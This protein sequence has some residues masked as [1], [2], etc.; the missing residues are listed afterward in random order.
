[1]DSSQAPKDAGGSGAQEFSFLTIV[2]SAVRDRRRIMTA[3]LGITGV[4][5]LSAL[6]YYVFVQPTRHV[7]STAFR[8]TFDRA[9]EDLYPNGLPFG[10]SDVI[11]PSV[12]QQVFDA[13][14][15]GDY[16]PFG[17]FK[18]GLVVERGATERRLVDAQYNG[19][20]SNARLTPV[21]RQ[22]LEEE[23]RARLDALP[24]E[25]RL[26]FVRPADC[27][28][29]GEI[30]SAALAGILETWAREAEQKRG[31]LH[32]DVSVAGPTMFDQTAPVPYLVARVDFT[33]NAITRA[34]DAVDRIAKLPGALALRSGGRNGMTLM[35]VRGR[36]NDLRERV[37]EPLLVQAA[38][39][40]GGDAIAWLDS[41]RAS[42]RIE[43]ESSQ[44]RAE[45]FRT[46]IREFSGGPQAA[47]AVARPS[48]T[49]LQGGQP[50]GPTTIPQLDSS[51][52][53]R[54]I[55]LSSQPN[56]YR[57]ELTEKMVAHAESASH[58]G[59][60]EAFYTAIIES[61]QRG[62]PRLDGAGVRQQLDLVIT[63]GKR[64]VEELGNFY[65]ELNEVGLHPGAAMYVVTERT[66]ETVSRPFGRSD[67]VLT[68]LAAFVI[69]LML[70]PVLLVFWE[71]VGGW[72]PGAARG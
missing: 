48:S 24:V 16:C 68:V 32:Y 4:V 8:V 29:P 72:T 10:G 50:E 58:S 19:L 9:Q 38:R 67:L 14:S 60:E 2:R 36:L 34:L 26:I 22:R 40:G 63:E 5:A 54:I 45:A 47:S 46:A 62:G 17:R 53:E 41:A 31:V 25:Y 56:E 69:S 59:T 7:F 11:S 27:Q 57:R 44:T 65:G 43:K 6:V 3:V 21:E 37:V 28:I 39:G 18:G 35:E 20:L 66:Q 52:I 49:G 13:H 55:Q 1:M 15:L 61:A 42:A 23:Y 51:F 12:V 30:T 70:V 33:R 64:L 71:R